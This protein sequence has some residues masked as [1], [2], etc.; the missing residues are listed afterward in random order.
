[1]LR[2][3]YYYYYYYITNQFKP[4]SLINLSSLL[5]TRRKLSPP[6]PS[7][8]TIHRSDLFCLPA[9]DRQTAIFLPSASARVVY[10][11][12]T[13]VVFKE[14]A[15]ERNLV[16]SGEKILCAYA[17]FSAQLEDAF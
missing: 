7:K 6:L 4:S 10:K 14:G 8:A 13:M 17:S 2:N 3:P 11:W 12:R 5:V 1:M 16:A 15:H 9:N